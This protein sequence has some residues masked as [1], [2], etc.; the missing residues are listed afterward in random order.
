MIKIA[1]HF[2]SD[3]KDIAG[4]PPLC[5]GYL[6]SYLKKYGTEVEMRV[7][8]SVDEIISYKPD[9]IALSSTT[10]DYTLA[11]KLA[12]ELK[13]KLSA[14][15][16]LGGVHITVLPTNLYPEFDVGIMGEGEETLNELVRLFER[17]EKFEPDDLK[18]IS[19]I[20]FKS[21]EKFF[22]TQ[23]QVLIEP[24]DKIPH[25]DRVLIGQSSDEAYMFTSRGCPYKCSFCSSQVHWGKY[26]TF[27][28][29]YVVEEIEQLHSDFG[30]K[31][32]HFYDDLFVADI[33]RF[34]RIAEL[35]EKSG[36]IG[37][38]EFS[39][40]IRA[41]LANERLLHS[42]RKMGIKRVTFGAESNSSKILKY[43]KGTGITPESN[44]QA[45]DMCNRLGIRLSP[46]FIKGS[47][48]ETGD[49]LMETYNFLIKNIRN[50]KI[51]YFEFHVLTPFPGTKVWDDAK[52]MGII[53]ENLDDWGKLRYP[54]EFFYMNRAMPKSTFYFFED[55]NQEAQRMLGIFKHRL[56]ALVDMHQADENAIARAKALAESRFFNLLLCFDLE[57]LKKPSKEEQELASAGYSV[58]APQSIFDVL[59][60]DKKY[61][62]YC[63]IRPIEPFDVE[64]VKNLVWH[65]YNK[66]S[67]LTIF[68]PYK[69]FYP[70]SP[71]EKELYVMNSRAFEQVTHDYLDALSSKRPLVPAERIVEKWGRVGLYRPETDPFYASHETQQLFKNILWDKFGASGKKG[72]KLE[73]FLLAI[74]N[75]IEQ[76]AKELPKIESRVRKLKENAAIKILRRIFKNRE[77][78]SWL[79]R[80]AKRLLYRE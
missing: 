19:G 46:S 39:C 16:L 48:D 20:V 21:E 49:D 67:D 36:L 25:P 80:V 31:K 56:V 29:E 44:Q 61:D 75:R 77:K 78:P 76:K 59:G 43:L 66:K 68:A 73:K 8:H 14:P 51:D 11:R 41:N 55:L 70:V 10:L 2:V 53:A 13:Q 22:I 79:V 40:A 74:D 23:P 62:I 32:I 50:K 15:I 24:L 27:S 58:I 9:I 72:E 34:E 42:I 57:N 3:V 7:L 6:Y 71:F 65:H 26:R 30:I 33:N 28:P 35:T 38:I 52:A 17:K 69:F 12:R 60:E 47:P 4:Y 37:K 54:G 18:K 1:A 64:A 45:V 63:F 5:F